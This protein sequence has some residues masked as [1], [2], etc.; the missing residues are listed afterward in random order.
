VAKK[1]MVKNL[2]MM[3]FVKLKLGTDFDFHGISLYCVVNVAL[4]KDGLIR[5]SMTTFKKWIEINGTHIKNEAIKFK[6]P[7]LKK[8]NGLTQVKKIS[9]KAKKKDAAILELDRK[10]NL[11]IGHQN[12]KTKNFDKPKLLP[13]TP[14]IASNEFLSS[15]EWRRL[16]MQALKLY[17]AKCQCCGATPATGAVMNVDH[18]KPR[19]LFPNLALELSNLQVLCHE[20]NH[21]KGNWDMTDWRANHEN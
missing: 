8:H 1:M 5:P 2:E 13:S 11:P 12:R 19:K 7:F 21:G 20:C 15:Y 10:L 3:R 4:E 9:K 14:P 17:S 16:R 18:I 6:E